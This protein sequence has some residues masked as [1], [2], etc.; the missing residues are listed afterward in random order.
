MCN[1]NTK[2]KIIT[3]LNKFKKDTQREKIIT[4]PKI[5]N[6]IYKINNNIKKRDKKR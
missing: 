6:N 2:I 1:N 3:I 5:A 4:V